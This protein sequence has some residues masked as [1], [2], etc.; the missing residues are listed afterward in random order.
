MILVTS[1]TLWHYINETNERI[2][3]T[4]KTLKQTQNELNKQHEETQLVYSEVNDM[5]KQNKSL[6]KLNTYSA[7]ELIRVVA[8]KEG[9]DPCLAVAISRLET[10]NYTSDIFKQ[11]HN[12]G[13]MKKGDTWLHYD[14]LIEGVNAYILCLKEEYYDKGLKTPEQIQPKYC[15]NSGGGQNWL[16]QVKKIMEEEV[17]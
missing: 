16:K 4:N 17:N 8:K 12:V 5:L 15:P 14:S 3:N 13:G 10:A 2:N 7:E 9:I 6:M 11:N 1:C